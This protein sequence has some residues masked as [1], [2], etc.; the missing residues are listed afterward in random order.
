MRWFTSIATESA[1]P[2]RCADSASVL[3]GFERGPIGASF[4]WA[5]ARIPVRFPISTHTDQPAVRNAA[6]VD[7]NSFTYNPE[8]RRDWVRAAITLSLNFALLAIAGVA[9]YSA[10][11]DFDKTKELLDELLPALTGLIGS[12]LGFYFGSKSSNA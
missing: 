6:P 4:S 1:I 9:L 12:A 5:S 11:G 8:P 3:S 10:H 2:C 7:A